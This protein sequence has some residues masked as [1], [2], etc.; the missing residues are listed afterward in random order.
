M[1]KALELKLKK[2]GFEVVAVYDGLQAI[3][4]IKSDSFTLVLLDIVMP[5]MDGLE[6]LSYLRNNSIGKKIEVIILTNLSNG[7]KTVEAV[8]CV[9]RD[10]LVK[11]DWKI[12][13]LIAKV[14]EKL[15]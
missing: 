15:K 6:M 14:K 3:D 12:S 11:S 1:S 2:E 13:D 7:A 9:V 4:A 10:Y 5:V 8:E